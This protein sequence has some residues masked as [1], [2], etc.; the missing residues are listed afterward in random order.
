[1]KKLLF[2]LMMMVFSA[3][4]YAQY[5][6]DRTYWGA[7]LSDLNLSDNGING[8]HIGVGA[9]VGY[10]VSNKTL[11]FAQ[12]NYTYYESFFDIFEA[13]AFGRYYFM[14]N[15]GFYTGIGVNLMWFEGV[16][17]EPSIHV[18]YSFPLNKYVVVEPELYYNQSIADHSNYS[19]LGFRLGFGIVL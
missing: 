17:V 18:G 15:G 1:M 3:E 10:F 11:L 7:S 5:E 4:C 19:T 14:N 16:D 12:A 13:G 2:A 6:K 8:F 9:K